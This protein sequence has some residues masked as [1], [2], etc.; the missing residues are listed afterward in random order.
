ME[1]SVFRA[2]LDKMTSE[3]R[4][5]SVVLC[6]WTEPFLHPQID[7][8]VEAVNCKNIACSLSTNLSFEFSSRLEAVL[9]HAPGIVISVSGFSQEM[10]ELYHKG[11][12]LEVIK[13]NL[14]FISKLR[15]KLRLALHVEIHCLEFIDNQE[16]QLQ[17]ESYCNDYGFIFRSKPAFCSDVTSPETAGRLLYQPSFYQESDGKL[18]ISRHF[19]KIPL[20]K[21]CALHNTIPI[22]SQG[23]VFLC[24][25][26]WNHDQYKIGNFLNTQLCTIQERRLLHHDC[27]H[28]TV[29]RQ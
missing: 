20:A 12:N 2:I 8:F 21:A 6:N 14:Q 1:L 24:C 27:A 15:E 16:D 7:K 5:H 10:H 29:L 19:S 23:D 25:I 4:C 18:K 3:G 13:K 11:S 26:Y 28:C 17:W 9:Q 22:D